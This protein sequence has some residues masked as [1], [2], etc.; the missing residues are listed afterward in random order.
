[1]FGDQ[2]AAG[3]VPWRMQRVTWA[4]ML[5]RKEGASVGALEATPGALP[6]S[7]VPFPRAWPLP[8]QGKDP[9]SQG[10]GAQRA[11]LLHG[12]V[13]PHGPSP[14]HL[15]PRRGVTVSERPLPLPAGREGP[16][17]RV[18]GAPVRPCQARQGHRAAEAPQPGPSRAGPRAAAG[19]VRLQ[20]G[21]GEAGAPVEGVAEG[22]GWGGRG[23][24]DRFGCPR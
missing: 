10:G 16:A 3:P 17:D 2:G 15:L 13:W 20:A 23:R 19:R 24:T 5:A 21:G 1:M 8:G 9:S 18:Q 11:G 7:C 22:P 4:S 12:G 6:R 14:G